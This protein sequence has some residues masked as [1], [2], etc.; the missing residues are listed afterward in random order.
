[1]LG[2]DFIYLGST[3][4]LFENQIRD[5]QGSKLEFNL[6]GAVLC[7]ILLIFGLYYFIIRKNA[8]LIDAFLFGLVI[9][10]V[11]ETTNYAILKKWRPLT[12][13]MDTLWGA[14]LM[15]T[16]TYLTYSFYYGK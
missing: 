2:L 4:Y 12:V 15:T 13:I 16:T 7:Y 1:M 5:I 9:Y 6:V 3:R 14:V 10:G 11:Y 8:E